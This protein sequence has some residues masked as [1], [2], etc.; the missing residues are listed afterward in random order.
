MRI[1][2]ML[3]F[4]CGRREKVDGSGSDCEICREEDGSSSEEK[5]PSIGFAATEEVLRRGRRRE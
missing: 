5:E 4:E 3:D 2:L 1:R